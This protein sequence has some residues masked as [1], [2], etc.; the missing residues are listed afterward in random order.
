MILL[1]LLLAAV[2]GLAALGAQAQPL[3]PVSVARGLQHPWG[4][5]FLPDGRL[6]VTERPGRLR[7]VWPDGTLS[8][9]WPGCRP[10]MPVAKAAC[11]T[12]PSTLT[13]P[14]PAWCT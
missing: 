5:A 12:W 13:L 9:P 7:I 6:L 8:P 1:R 14:P 4:L 11:S 3:K 2:L 10:S